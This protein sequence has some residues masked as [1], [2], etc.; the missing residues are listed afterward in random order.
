MVS[1]R[2]KTRNGR[3]TSRLSPVKRAIVPNRVVRECVSAAWTMTWDVG[4]GT[5]S[6][7]KYHCDTVA[8]VMV[9]CK[10]NDMHFDAAANELRRLSMWL[11]GMDE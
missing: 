10:P 7:W 1:L 4:A 6:R 8:D 9:L 11:A 2:G 3:R 5:A